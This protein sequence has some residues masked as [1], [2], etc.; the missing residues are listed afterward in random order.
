MKIPRIFFFIISLILGKNSISQNE[1]L[2]MPMKDGEVLYEFIVNVDSNYL[3]KDIFNKIKSWFVESFKDS[4]NVLEIEDLENGKLTGKGIFNIEP[5]IL[6]S[7]ATDCYFIINVDVKNS[8]YRLQI[9]DMYFERLGGNMTGDIRK[10]VT[11]I[12]NGI[13]NGIPAYKIFMDSKKNALRNQTLFL[14][15]VDEKVN[16][17]AKSLNKYILE[18]ENNDW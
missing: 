4:K 2:T 9:Y 1:Q 17:I 11:E 18:K 13:K 14:K 15:N 5:K 16:A 3:G 8:K 7:P 6:N 12:Y 10:A